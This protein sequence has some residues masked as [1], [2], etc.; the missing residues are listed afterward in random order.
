MPEWSDMARTLCD[1]LY[2]ASDK[3]RRESAM[4]EAQATSGFLRLAQEFEAVF[5][6]LALHERIRTLVPDNDYEPDDLHRRLL[7]LPWADIFTTNWDTLLERTCPDVFEHSYDI[8]RVPSEIPA[9]ARPRI[10]KLH[11]S[12]PAYEPFI[13]TEE[14]FRTY[15][16]KFASFVNLVQQSMME[17]VFCLIGF[18]GD[19]PNF[20][21]W[22][23]W[24]RDNLGRSA[25]KIHLVGW[26]DL[27]PH[28]RRMLEDRNVV[29]IDLAGLPQAETWPDLAR[30]RY[31]IEWFLGALELGR[32]PDPSQ[33]PSPP[34]TSPS[35]P[36]YLGDIPKPQMRVPRHERPTPN[37]QQELNERLLTAHAIVE[38]W[39]WN[40][41]LYPGWLVAPSKVRSVLWVNTRAW[42]SEV[43]SMVPH[44]SPVKLL[45]VL[46][47]LVWRLDTA[48]LPLFELEAPCSKV[49][50][51]IDLKQKLVLMDDGTPEDLAD[52]PWSTVCKAGETLAIALAR[53]ARER[54]DKSA[55]DTW[56]KCFE[57]C[58]AGTA[59]VDQHVAYEQCLWA[60]ARLDYD[61]LANHL[62]Q[63]N[64]EK[65]DP[66]W[67]LRKAGILAEINRD[68]DAIS[69]LKGALT[70]IRRHRRRDLDDLPAL[71]REAWA[72]WPVL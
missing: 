18:S 60:L 47:E 64:P 23:G 61:V 59:E 24:V 5:G 70:E 63:W 7:S 2:P 12:F 30:H 48:L 13:F 25:P 66:V 21:H 68:Q 58:A 43:C 27:S 57:E 35:P 31:A 67:A 42:L 16:T 8:V 22:S 55:F 56:L 28:R 45:L 39:R 52:V 53:S 37:A 62:V 65:A 17:T 10:V 6:R 20:L 36:S 26:L 44:L 19:D 71:S 72:L 4:R 9:A 1:Q 69:L 46:R 15:P 41:E 54:G 11:G 29:P 34:P 32:P 49:L 50:E 38:T 40:R 14:D 51:A 33:W 3:E